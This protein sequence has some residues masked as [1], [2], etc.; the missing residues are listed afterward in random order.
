MTNTKRILPVLNPRTGEAD[1]EIEAASPADVAA[2]AKRLRGAQPEWLARGFDGRAAA[3]NALADQ[4]EQDAQSVM[5]ALEIDTGRRRLAQSEVQGVIG[6]LRGW[7]MLAPTLLP[8][9]DWIPGRTKP[10]FKHQTEYV[11]YQLT[12]VISPWNFPITLSFID[13]VQA[14]MAGSCV[15]IKPSEVTPRFADALLPI[16]EAA[17]LSDI[18]GFVQGDGATGAAIMPNV[19]C[20]CFTGSVATGRKV[21]LAA[22]ENLIPANLEL[23]GKDPMIITPSADMEEATTLAL[24]ASSM[25][26]EG[27]II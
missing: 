5:D 23:G 16:I 14:L 27:V 24:R 21:A 1:Y 13:A 25:S 19:D 10:N 26:A 20:V 15:I 9:L 6:M 18:I 3:L 7:A 4:L 12:G 17:G 2:A 8:E 22:A 11:P